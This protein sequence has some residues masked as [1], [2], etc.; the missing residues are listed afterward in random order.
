MKLTPCRG[1]GALVVR[2]VHETMH[3][4]SEHNDRHFAPCGLPCLNGGVGHEVI[5]PMRAAGKGLRDV[6]HTA[7]MC[8]CCRTPAEIV[9]P[10]IDRI[11]ADARADVRAEVEHDEAMERLAA[12]I[13][14][15]EQGQ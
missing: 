1:C 10:K 8:P 6:T 14:R 13:D 3:G 7:D 9:K 4:Q 12:A 2:R 15:E 11:G 5:R